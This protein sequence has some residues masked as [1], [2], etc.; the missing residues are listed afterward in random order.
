MLL[1]DSVEKQTINMQRVKLIN[2]VTLG[3][4]LYALSP[5]PASLHLLLMHLFTPLENEKERGRERG[6]RGSGELFSLSMK[7]ASG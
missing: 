7:W 4:C 2:E 3:Q 6:E 5:P 1:Q